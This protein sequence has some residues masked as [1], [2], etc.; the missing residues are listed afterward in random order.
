M[1]V[2]A[3]LFCLSCSLVKVK[4]NCYYF[5]ELFTL[6]FITDLRRLLLIFPVCIHLDFCIID[7]FQSDYLLPLFA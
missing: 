2:Q 6:W 5:K 1:R 7:L 3:A 4:G